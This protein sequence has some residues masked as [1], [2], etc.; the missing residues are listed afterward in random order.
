MIPVK[1]VLAEISR[2]KDELITPAEFI[3]TNQADI[4]LKKIGEVYEEYQSS[5]RQRTP[6]TLTI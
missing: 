1:S 2:A 6:W 5:S 3:S 4:R